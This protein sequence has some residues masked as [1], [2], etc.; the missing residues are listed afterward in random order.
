MYTSNNF[1][2]LEGGSYENV[3]YVIVNNMRLEDIFLQ[4]FKL[5][6]R[7]PTGMVAADIRTIYPISE[8]RTVDKNTALQFSLGV[9]PKKLEGIGRLIQLFVKTLFTTPGTNIFFKTIG[10]GLGAVYK[11]GYAMDQQDKIIPDIITAVAK[12]ERDIKEM[13]ASMRLPFDER[14]ISAT[15]ASTSVDPNSGTISFITT[16]GTQQGDNGSFSLAF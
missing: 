3:K 10:G 2:V 5:Y 15:V 16:L 11:K 6:I 1:I 14:L 9:Y 12:T 7:L 13:Q 8:T 4:G